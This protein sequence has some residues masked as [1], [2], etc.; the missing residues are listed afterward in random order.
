MSWCGLRFRQPA[1]CSCEGDEALHHDIFSFP[2]LPLKQWRDDCF[3]K[4]RDCSSMV[5]KLRQRDLKLLHSWFSEDTQPRA[6]GGFYS[7]L[8]FLSTSKVCFDPPSF[9]VPREDWLPSVDIP[10]GE[11]AAFVCSVSGTGFTA[12]WTLWLEPKLHFS[13]VWPVNMSLACAATLQTCTEII[14]EGDS[15]SSERTQKEGRRV[16]VSSYNQSWSRR[17]P[18]TAVQTRRS[19]N[20]RVF[21]TSFIYAEQN[22]PALGTGQQ[23]FKA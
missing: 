4:W 17:I 11:R 13:N 5:P 6:N 7:T 10:G 9:Q 22:V 8:C 21:D 16:T 1:R 3:G 2:A 15:S 20:G 14:W 19:T 18:T 12:A 23:L